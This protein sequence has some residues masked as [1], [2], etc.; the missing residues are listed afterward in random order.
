MS[1]SH[2]VA[3]ALMA[4]PLAFL[5]LPLYVYVPA[6]YA[7]LPG[8]GLAVVGTAL[9]AARLLD[10]FTD[11]IVGIVSD[12]LR[13]RV[14]PLIWVGIGVPA[15]ASGVHLLFNPA[16]DATVWYLLI[17]VSLT[18]LGW[19]LIAVPYYALGA[20][21]THQAQ[22]RRLLAFWR[23]AGM[24]IGALLAL[25]VAALSVDSALSAMSEIL[26]WLLPISAIA[27]MIPARHAKPQ[28][29][30]TDLGRR[31][32]KQ[33]WQH[34]S[35]PMRRLLSLHFINA[36]AAG[37]P[38]TLFLLYTDNVLHI[39][40]QAGGLLLLMYFLAG[41]LSLP[42]WSAIAERYGSLQTWRIALSVAA[43]CFLPAAFLGPG[44]TYLFA[45]VCLLTGA[46]LGADIALPASI[47]AHLANTA[48]D[49]TQQPQQGMSFGLWGMT[50]KLALACAVGITFPLL[51]LAPTEHAQAQYL[52]W[53][54]ALLPVVL[55]VCAIAL[56]STS[57][58]LFTGKGEDDA[59]E[60]DH[61]ENTR[62][63]PIDH[64]RFERV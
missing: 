25:I 53:L 30:S 3:Y 37:I 60:I 2:Y 8:I 1:Q 47:Q 18:F 29:A 17:S 4:V 28:L 64:A 40:Q 22:P 41:I 24:L 38:A 46:T 58:N 34:V 55:K 52:P 27:L 43:L 57:M 9:F 54:Y 42:L 10:L 56:L 13:Q 32:L 36:L 14:H 61:E 26:L 51:S 20:E 33:L 49:T 12:R 11:P 48:S 35:H 39:S 50:G 59:Q 5:G 44:D 63:H 21:I 45:L 6:T 62:N 19:T 23:E 15:M 16:S 7:D 31:S